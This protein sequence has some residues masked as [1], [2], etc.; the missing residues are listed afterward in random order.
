MG[1]DRE[2]NK[3]AGRNSVKRIFLFPCVIFPAFFFLPSLFPLLS[4][5]LPLDQA[6]V[7]KRQRLR[8]YFSLRD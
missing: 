7:D 8:Y 1:K 2:K 3:S 5:D 4:L 6:R